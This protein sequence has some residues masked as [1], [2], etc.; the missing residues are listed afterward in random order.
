MTKEIG[1]NFDN[2]YARL[3]KSFFTTLNPTPVS[4]PKLVIFNESLGTYLGVER[5]CVTK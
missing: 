4:S 1:W 5:Q 2:S 3:P